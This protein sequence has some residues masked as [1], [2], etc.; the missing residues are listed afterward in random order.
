MS[1]RL[2]SGR[3]SVWPIGKLWMQP[4]AHGEDIPLCP[5]WEE[6]SVHFCPHK[7]VP[8][9]VV[10]SG[11]FFDGRD[12]SWLFRF[13]AP[14]NMF[15]CACWEHSLWAQ[16]NCFALLAVALYYMTLR[17]LTYFSSPDAIVIQCWLILCL[18][19]NLA[20][21]MCS[22]ILRLPRNLLG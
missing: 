9:R 17:Q 10:Q 2:P 6:N 15:Q 14:D 18:H 3:A 7:G 19:N 8:V 1:K 13:V 21:V 5:F 4:H 11:A 20:L 22:G 12:V 16:T